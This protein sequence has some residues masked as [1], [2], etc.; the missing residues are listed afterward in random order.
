MSEQLDCEIVRDLLPSYV[1]WQ[2]SETTN[3]AI[4]KHISGCHECTEI[5]QRMKEPDDALQSQKNEIDYLKKVKKSEH[6][7]VLIA[8][9]A[10][11]LIGLIVYGIR[12]FVL[13]TETD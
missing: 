8:I 3:I 2:T 4:E 13:G 11:L 9:V 12:V 6:H 7:A 5:L 10:T 1:D